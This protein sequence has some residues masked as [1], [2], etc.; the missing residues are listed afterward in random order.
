MYKSFFIF[1]FVAALHTLAMPL[2]WQ[3]N[4]NILPTGLSWLFGGLL[5]FLTLKNI[6]KFSSISERNDMFWLK[7]YL[8]Y[9]SGS[10]VTGAVIADDYWRYKFLIQHSLGLLLFLACYLFTNINAVQYT[11]RCYYRY[12]APFFIIIFMFIPSNT[13]IRYLIIFNILIVFTPLLKRKQVIIIIFFALFSILSDISNRG[14][15]L[16]FIV[17]LI[18]IFIYIFNHRFIKVFK[19][20]RK[21]F[22]LLPFIFVSLAIFTNFNVFKLSD[23]IDNDYIITFDTSEN[24]IRQENLLIDTRTFLYEEVLLSAIKNNYFILGRTPAKGNETIIWENQT[25]DTGINERFFNEAAI[26]NVFTYMGL[27]GVL[28]YFLVFLRASYLAIYK[29]KNDFSI[30][31]GTIVAFRWLWS[32]V[33]DHSAL[34]LNYLSITILLGLCYSEDFRKLSNK[35][36]KLWARGIFNF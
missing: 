4:I 25:S 27:I 19:T 31:L 9:L 2:Q 6:I 18:L 10:I 35:D 33:G 32:W 24:D 3:S 1:L 36:V 28:L 5:L 15:V 11:L 13:Y 29:S 16:T 22:I 14:K 34:D 26:L 17:P 8:I 12:F 20:I 7:C 21:V 23:Y 30:I